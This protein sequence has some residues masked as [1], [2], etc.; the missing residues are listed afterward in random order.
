MAWDGL[1]KM[2]PRLLGRTHGVWDGLATMHAQ[3]L[4]WLGHDAR[5]GTHDFWDAR[6]AWDGLGCTH[7]F[8]DTLMVFG[9]QARLWA[10]SVG[11]ALDWRVIEA[12]TPS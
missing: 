10:N 3:L 9:M 5:I 4:E 11:V 8:L 7:G 2:N 6:M 1:A 12:L